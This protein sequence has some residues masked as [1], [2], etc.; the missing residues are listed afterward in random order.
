MDKDDVMSL[1]REISRLKSLSNDHFRNAQRL[2]H[3]ATVREDE[4][5]EA[6]KLIQQLRS[7]I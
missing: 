6:R 3:L 2:A 4:L 7:D 5:F 1:R